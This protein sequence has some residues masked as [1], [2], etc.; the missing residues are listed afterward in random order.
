MQ[1]ATL[2][3]ETA[4]SEP[5]GKVIFSKGQR[6]ITPGQ[7]VVFYEGEKVLGGGIIA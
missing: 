7:S 1:P 5:R 4:A 6:A 2:S 3:V